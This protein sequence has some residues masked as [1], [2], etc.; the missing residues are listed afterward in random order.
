LSFSLLFSEAW[1][2][3]A[4]SPKPAFSLCLHLRK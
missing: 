1:D 4:S 3:S 2:N